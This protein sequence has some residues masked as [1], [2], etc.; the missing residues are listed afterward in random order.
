MELFKKV[1][2]F[3][4]KD[5][6]TKRKQQRYCGVICSYRGKNKMAFNRYIADRSTHA[7]EANT[8]SRKIQRLKPDSDIA[9]LSMD[10]ER[11]RE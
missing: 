1:C 7:E 4:Y 6:H 11:Y 9:G 5:F 2:R 8:D 3:C 10:R